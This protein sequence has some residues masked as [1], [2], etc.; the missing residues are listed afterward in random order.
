MN[1]QIINSPHTGLEIQELEQ[2]RA[3]MQQ[4]VR[5]HYQS[6]MVAVSVPFYQ[7]LITG[8][9]A[10]VL[11]AILIYAFGGSTKYIFVGF[12][13]TTVVVTGIVWLLLIRNWQEL[14][15][16]MEQQ[17]GIDLTGD[18]VIGRPGVPLTIRAEI[19]RNGGQSRTFT[20]LSGAKLLEFFD[21]ILDGDDISEARWTPSQNGFSK[22]EYWSNIGNLIRSGVVRWKN[23]N[24][25]SQGVVLTPEGPEILEKW[26][27]DANGATP[28][29]RY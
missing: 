22:S 7:S 5:T 23:E 3:D 10:G 1:K 20:D 26:I 6:R 28:P 19:S 27:R 21:A 29:P 13:L 24:H 16:N 17:M 15:W 25:H 14:V 2:M 18:Q 8:L 4:R 9:L 11:V 12:A